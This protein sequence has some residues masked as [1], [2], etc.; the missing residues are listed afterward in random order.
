MNNEVHLFVFYILWIF[1]DVMLCCWVNSS[2]HVEGPYCHHLQG[3]AVQE[4]FD[5]QDERT[6]LS[7]TSALLGTFQTA[8][9]DEMNMNTDLK[10]TSK[11]EQQPIVNHTASIFSAEDE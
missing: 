9:K 2:G 1:W 6:V 7:E 3:Q 4:Q 10:T 8:S 5:P 11:D